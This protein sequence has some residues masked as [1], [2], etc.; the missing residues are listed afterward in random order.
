MGDVVDDPPLPNEWSLPFGERAEPDW[1]V[2]FDLLLD[3]GWF[4]FMH[5]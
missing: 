1:K 4:E 5:S 2:I 3:T